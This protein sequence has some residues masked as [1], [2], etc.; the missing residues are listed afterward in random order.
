VKARGGESRSAIRLHRHF[1]TSGL[2]SQRIQALG[3]ASRRSRDRA[4]PR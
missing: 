1:G 2:G 3:V 4:K